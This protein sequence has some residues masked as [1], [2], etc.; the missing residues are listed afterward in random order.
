MSNN[1]TLNLDTTGKFKIIYRLSN[2]KTI[3]FTATDKDGSPLNQISEYQFSVS[4]D[5]NF[6]DILINLTE[7]N[8]LLVVDNTIQITILINKEDCSYGTKFFELK[9]ITNNLSIFIG[10]FEI[11]KSLI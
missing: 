1:K 9:D 2:T 7:G 4:E 6:D 5:A 8:G 10:E 3:Q 11:L